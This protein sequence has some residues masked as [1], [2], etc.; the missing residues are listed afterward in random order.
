M[1]PAAPVLLVNPGRRHDGSRGTP[2]RRAPAQFHR[3]L[4]GYAPTRVVDAPGLAAELGLGEPD[5]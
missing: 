5:A 2:R 3:R 1:R 4:P